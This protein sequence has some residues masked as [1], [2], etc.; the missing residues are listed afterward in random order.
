MWSKALAPRFVKL[1]PHDYAGKGTPVSDPMAG[2]REAFVRR[3]EAQFAQLPPDKVMD[4]VMLV[5]KLFTTKH[6][7][8]LGMS[9]ETVGRL[10]ADLAKSARGT[11]R[12][13][14]GCA[15]L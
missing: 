15:E 5:K 7:A 6:V 8:G 2:R 13:D 11:V 9:E 1:Q 12:G 14:V 3:L 10:L 4:K